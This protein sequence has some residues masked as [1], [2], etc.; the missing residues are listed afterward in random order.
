L[1]QRTQRSQSFG[2]DQ[3]RRRLPQR[4]QR[5]QR[6]AQV[7][8][9]A[10]ARTQRSTKDTKVSN[11]DG[12]LPR[13]AR[14]T[15][16]VKATVLVS[17]LSS[18]VAS[19]QL[20]VATPFEPMPVHPVKRPTPESAYSRLVLRSEAPLRGVVRQSGLPSPVVVD[21]V[22]DPEQAK[23]VEGS[24]SKGHAFCTDYTD[25]YGFRFLPSN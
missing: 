25:G 19:C 15:L 11:G 9:T 14:N 17:P 6:T 8:L 3:R 24:L 18:P 22:G 10:T 21:P 13:K 23:R 1:P 16:M 5:S 12:F 20:P 7:W 2:Y 4:T